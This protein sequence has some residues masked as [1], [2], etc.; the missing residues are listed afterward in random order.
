MGPCQISS[1]NQVKFRW[2]LIFLPLSGV[3]IGK[4]IKNLNV[5]NYV[6]KVIDSLKRSYLRVE[7]EYIVVYYIV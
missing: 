2:E 6:R 1:M 7:Q 4:C 5:Q 3:K